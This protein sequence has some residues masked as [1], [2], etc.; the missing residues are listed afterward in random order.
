[1]TSVSS[2]FRHAG[3]ILAGLALVTLASAPALAQQPSKADMAIKYRQ[4]AYYLLAWNIGPL[5]AMAQGKVPYDAKL[6]ER[7]AT[8]MSQISAMLLEGFPPESKTGTTA[9]TK[10]RPE[11]W[12]NFDDFKAK[13]ADLQKATAKLAEAS[14]SGDLK[15][16]APVMQEVG[17]ACKACHDKYKDKD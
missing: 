9:T 13:M 11:I 5:G 17:N 1:M 14:K 16:A 3:S 7:N 2:K 6:F 15:R 12:T 4:S 8:R 10:A